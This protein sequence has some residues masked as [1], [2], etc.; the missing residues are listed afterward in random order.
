MTYNPFLDACTFQHTRRG[1]VNAVG[2]LV[3]DVVLLVTMLIG[4]LRHSNRNS[5]GIWKL[6]Y[7]Q[8]TLNKFSP[9]CVNIELLLV[10]N[11]VCVS[12]VCRDTSRGQSL[13]V[14]GRY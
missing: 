8:V 4:L 5:S 2:T 7:Q 12:L 9:S 11:L 1:L 3:V 10:Y 14:A 13:F 6:L